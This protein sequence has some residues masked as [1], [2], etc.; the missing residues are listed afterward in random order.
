MEIAK[1]LTE[2]KEN[3]LQEVGRF[4]LDAGQKIDIV[5]QKTPGVELPMELETADCEAVQ[6]FIQK[7][8]K[9]L[10]NFKDLLFKETHFV[11]RSEKEEKS[12]GSNAMWGWAP[13]DKFN[14]IAV[15]RI[16]QGRV[17]DVLAI[18][19]EIGHAL[20]PNEEGIEQQAEELKIATKEYLKLMSQRERFAWAKALSIAKKLK[21]EKGIDVLK[22]FQGKTPIETR[23]NLEEYIDGRKSLGYYERKYITRSEFSE[24]L[25]GLFTTKFYKG[26]KFSPEH[27]KKIRG[28]MRP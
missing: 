8:G 13:F 10:F 21:K 19:H 11:L 4:E 16:W 27:R 6:V 23:K 22:P 12:K 14:A 24:E 18:L 1:N 2:S 17:K 9:N 20:D 26:E 5:I 28:K 3:A 15:P 25:K 7:E